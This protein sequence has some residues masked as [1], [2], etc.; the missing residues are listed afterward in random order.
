MSVVTTN[1]GQH[2]GPIRPGLLGL[3]SEPADTTFAL[4]SQA[5][6]LITFFL[7]LGAAL[8][9]VRYAQNLPLWS[10]E[11]F[12]AANFIGRDYLGLVKPLENGQIAPILFLWIERFVL[13]LLGFSEWSLRLFPLLC[14][15]ASLVLFWHLARQ[16]LAGQPVALALAVGIMA[17][18]VHPIRHAADAKPYASDLLT[19]LMLLTPAVHWLRRPGQL[20]WLWLLTGLVP[21]ALGL[22]NPAV[23]VAGGIGLAIVGQV[24]RL[25][26]WK[27]WL[28]FASYGLVMTAAFG[29]LFSLVGQP[30]SPQVLEGLRTYWA[31]AFPPFSSVW[32]LAAWLVSMHTGSAFAYP[33]GGAR[34]GSSATFLACVVGAA[35]LAR[36]GHGSV[37]ACLLWPFALAFIAAGLRLYPYGSEARLMQYAA[38]SI[39]L[40]C[41]LGAV[42]TLECLGNLRLRR[43][44]LRLAVLGLVVCG[45]VPQ[46]VSSRFPYRMVYDHQ[47]REFAR[48][49]WVGQSSGADLNCAHLDYGVGMGQKWVGRKAWY[50]CNQMIYSPHRTGSARPSPR[51]PSL[52]RPLRCVLFDEPFE[53]PAVKEWL[54]A[55]Q[56][57]LALNSRT[58]YQVPVT[59]GEGRPDIDRWEVL[60]FVARGNEPAPDL[61][62]RGENARLRR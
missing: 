31:P 55:M 7:V 1:P 4:P 41:G 61:V 33:G 46:V 25:A 37:L 49:F 3:I 34:G 13:D 17:V 56:S 54:E 9:L 58:V 50:L 53:S 60:E 39:C 51:K 5:R 62:R 59:V 14:G 20:G 11:C 42:T 40:L 27:C 35:V 8:R 10:D 22:S 45:I 44:L 32:K 16:V 36:R 6:W 38:P 28:A 21:I 2:E 48:R 12:L 47:S 57:H 30:Q 23:F 24:R 19:A 18:S 26:S 15:L 29:L 43:N 52:Q